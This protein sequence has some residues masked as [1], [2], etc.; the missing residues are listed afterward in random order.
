[1]W[2]TM[3]T[4]LSIKEHSFKK[5]QIKKTGFYNELHVLRVLFIL[6]SCTETTEETNCFETNQNK[7]KQTEGTLN[8]VKKYRNMLSITLFR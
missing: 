6:S 5:K 7:P 3:I 4:D 1:V 8:F 2:L